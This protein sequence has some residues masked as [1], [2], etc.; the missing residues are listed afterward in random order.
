MDKTEDVVLFGFDLDDLD[1]LID[2]LYHTPGGYGHLLDIMRD[3]RIRLRK[4]LDTSQLH[5][6]QDRELLRNPPGIPTDTSKPC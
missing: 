1:M 2:I 3:N 6:T 5:G 4:P